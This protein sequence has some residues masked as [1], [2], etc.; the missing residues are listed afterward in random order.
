MLGQFS[1]WRDG[2]F[3]GVRQSVPGKATHERGHGVKRES[4]RSALIRG[5]ERSNYLTKILGLSE[6]D[7]KSIRWAANFHDVDILS[8]PVCQ[9]EEID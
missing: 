1:L 3:P 7:S 9:A 6:K 2:G 5:F 8:L 4:D